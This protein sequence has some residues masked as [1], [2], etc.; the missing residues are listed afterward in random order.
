ME[1]FFK[2]PQIL[3]FGILV[4]FNSISCRVDVSYIKNY[5]QKI[6]LAEFAYH[7][8]DYQK[9]F[10]SSQTNNPFASPVKLDPINFVILELTYSLCPHKQ[11]KLIPF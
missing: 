8:G 2:K 7:E 1:N 11:T 5:Y 9:C 6:Y 10:V 4:L 3:F